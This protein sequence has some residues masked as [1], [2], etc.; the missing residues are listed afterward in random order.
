MGKSTWYSVAKS[1]ALFFERCY[2]NKIIGNDLVNIG[3]EVCASYLK[4]I[5]ESRLQYCTEQKYIDKIR[6]TFSSS[7]FSELFEF[8]ENGT[9]L[10][11]DAGKKNIVYSAFN[12]PPM[13]AV[14]EDEY[15]IT[16][17][18]ISCIWKA[19]EVC[20]ELAE[21]Y[22]PSRT[23]TVSKLLQEATGDK[24][25]TPMSNNPYD[26]ATMWQGEAWRHLNKT[27]DKRS[28]VRNYMMSTFNF[29]QCIIDKAPNL[30]DDDKHKFMSDSIERYNNGDYSWE[31]WLTVIH[32]NIGYEINNS[33]RFNLDQ[34][35]QL[36]SIY[37]TA[38]NSVIDKSKVE[39]IFAD[40]C[41]EVQGFCDRFLDR[42][43]GRV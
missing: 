13:D 16:R 10:E 29:L 36:Y 34:M 9:G 21:E 37:R 43:I 22:S 18:E 6:D 26:I 8:I 19:I 39:S 27:G 35:S 32:V 23:S 4:V 24:E 1:S 7:G 14:G 42:V 25:P 5:A 12:L 3:W 15:N 41:K 11:L 30:S 40:G 28:A 17:D 20:K 2:V 38:D 33:L 31:P